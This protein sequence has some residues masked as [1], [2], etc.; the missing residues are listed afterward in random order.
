MQILP[1]PTCMFPL[2]AVGLSLSATGRNG[3]EK[4]VSC[5]CMHVHAYMVYIHTYTQVYALPI[6]IQ[7]IF[8]A[9]RRS[10]SVLQIPGSRSVFSPSGGAG[11]RTTPVF[12]LLAHLL[13]SFK[14]QSVR[15][16]RRDDHIC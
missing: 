1:Q 8:S 12:S 11:S 9:S 14:Y 6:Y 4:Q 10:A 3:V 15:L 7:W 5:M 2:I 13:M 16:F